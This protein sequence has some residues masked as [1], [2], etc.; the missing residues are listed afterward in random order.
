MYK[1]LNL[2]VVLFVIAILFASTINA[3]WIKGSG[4][5]IE[6]ERTLDSFKSIQNSSSADVIIT[7][8]DKITVIVESDKNLMPHIVTKVIDNSLQ[9]KIEKSYRNIDVLKIKI[10]MPDIE[11]IKVSGS[12]D[13][14]FTDTFKTKN[15]E[16]N[17]SGSGDFSGKLDVNR[18][19]YKVNGSGDG[20]FSGVTGD[21]KISIS[22]SGDIDASNLRLAN[23]DIKIAGSGD[24]TIGGSADNLNLIQSGS[25]DIDAYQLKAVNVT[26]KL[27][28]SG[29]VECY[30]IEKLNAVTNGSGDVYYRGDPSAVN[31]NSN[32][33]GEIY[34]K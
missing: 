7:Q 29:D 16:V 1:K 34:K 11:Y 19:E 24:V 22:G 32:G 9:I 17:I 27:S 26:V 4:E 20:D 15:L 25:G 3:Q 8:G 31:A 13:I 5:I 18:L 28:G 30:V 12:G 23:C 21:L 2:S 10:T 14:S 33:S 6:E